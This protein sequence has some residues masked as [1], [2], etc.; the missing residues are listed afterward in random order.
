MEICVYPD[1][2]EPATKMLNDVWWCHDH[3]G[4]YPHKCVKFGCEKRPVYD[5]EPCCF[6]HSPDEG[7]SVRGYSAYKSEKA[8]K[9]HLARQNE[10][11]N[12]FGRG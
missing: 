10:R 8:M 5:D 9:E 12:Q 2:N 4:L 1:C 3:F 6:E 11:I 7:S